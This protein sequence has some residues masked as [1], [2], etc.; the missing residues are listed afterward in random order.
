LNLK[1][2][3]FLSIC[4][5]STTFIGQD[6]D[7]RVLLIL[8]IEAAKDAQINVLE[9]PYEYVG[10]Y[11]LT[12]LDFSKKDDIFW[13]PVDMTL[14]VTQTNDRQSREY[15]IEALESKTFGFSVTG[16]YGIQG[17][18]TTKN[19]VYKDMS[20]INYLGSCPPIGSCWRCA[21][22]RTSLFYQ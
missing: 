2:V 11:P 15:D 22:R 12:P 19:I 5:Y 9:A 20:R 1:L 8:S 17:P 16:N 3:F 21:P 14:A 13:E 18:T 7:T 10:S 4:F 6:L